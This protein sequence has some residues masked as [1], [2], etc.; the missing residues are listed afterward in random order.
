MMRKIGLIA[1]REFLTTVGNKGF[2]IG[3]LI[4]PAILGLA[5]VLG[6]RIMNARSPQIRG[7]VAVIDPTGRVMGQLRRELDPA[8]IQARRDSGISRAVGQVASG[9]GPAAGAAA[10]RI[11]G[12]PPA[13]RIVERPVDADVEREKNWLIAPATGITDERHLALVA[14]HPDAVVR[15]D[16]RPEYGSYDLFVSTSLDSNTEGVIFEA[17]RQS[18]VGARIEASN[19][20]QEAVEATMRVARPESII[21]AA[22]G[23]QRS[24]RGFTRALPFIMGML[25]F[26]GIMIGG[27]TLMTSTIEEKSSRVVEVLLAAV[28]PMELMA[29]KLLGQLG[30]GLLVMGVYVGLGILALFQFA[31]LGLLDPM[32][33]MYLVVFYLLSYLVFGALMSA[34]GAAVNEM[35]EAQSLMGPVMLCL[36]APYILTPMIQR[37]PESTFSVAMSFIPPVNTFAMMAR[38][39]SDAPPPLWQVSLTVVIGLAAAA[40]AVWFAAKVFK[41]GLLMHGKP[42]SFATLVRW[43]RQ[44]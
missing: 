18:L 2:L 17:L 10:Q 14:I 4:M 23:E 15:A 19:L 7:D 43:A 25:L 39:A 35:A 8:T 31:M 30:V 28:S 34:I 27:Q 44:A 37:A 42:P 11:I 41:I 20:D 16:G 36:I 1:A 12:P 32:L 26:I 24:Q 21:V 29:G 6:P 13:L 9:A 3:L 5:A 33:V 22:G 40:A 38:L